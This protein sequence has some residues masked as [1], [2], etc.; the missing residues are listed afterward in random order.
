MKTLDLSNDEL[1]TLREALEE[2]EERLVRKRGQRLD[3]GDDMTLDIVNHE[4]G[5]CQ[6][7]LS[8]VE[9]LND[10]LPK[11]YETC[12]DCGFDHAYEQAEAQEAHEVLAKRVQ[13]VA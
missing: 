10:E 13:E 8:R 3:A 12:G 11:D 2:L 7:L 6:A 5:E 4:L 9:A 1:Q